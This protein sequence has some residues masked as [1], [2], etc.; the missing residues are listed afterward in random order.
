MTQQ[1]M[2]IAFHIGAHKTATSHLQRSLQAASAALAAAGLCYLGPET[3]RQPRQSLAALFGM[4][5]AGAQLPALAAQYQR[6]LISEEN[7]IGALNPPRRRPVAQRYPDA[8]AR[9]D[10]IAAA[11]GQKIDLFVGLRRPTAYL[12]A[13]YCQQLLG[14]RVM[15]MQQYRK[16]HPLASV[17]WLDLI[18]RLRMAQGAGRITVWCYEDYAAHFPALM[19]AMLG[20]DRADLACP[21]DQRIHVSLSAAAVAEVLHRHQG[22]AT[23]DLALIARRLLPVAAGYPRFDGFT[24]ADHAAADTAY[25]AQIAAIAAIKDVTMLAPL[26]LG[27]ANRG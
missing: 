18:T 16:L 20:A 12:N 4:Q 6:L 5:G 23:A 11:A 27:D 10:A 8:A 9:I 15:S 3:L 21:I 24:A 7:Y 26:W 13:A 17:D 22:D 1:Q 14:G 2:S 19:A 25:A